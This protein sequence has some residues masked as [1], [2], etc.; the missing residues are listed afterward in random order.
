LLTKALKDQ[1]GYSL[2]EVMVSIMILTVAI[3]PMVGMFDVGLRAASTSDN[4][5]QARALANANLEAAK[6]MSFRQAA[7]LSSC[8]RDDAPNFDCDVVTTYVHLISTGTGTARFAASGTGD[9]RDMVKV[10]VTVEWGDGSQYTISGVVG[11]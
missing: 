11:K 8:P 4:Y 7:S 1:S 5:D 2:V 6:G 9:P 3:I 10:T